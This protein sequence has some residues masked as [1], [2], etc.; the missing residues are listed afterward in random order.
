MDKESDGVTSALEKQDIPHPW[1]CLRHPLSVV[2]KIL[3]LL[4]KDVFQI[5]MYNLWSIQL[6]LFLKQKPEVV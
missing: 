3:F 4:L 6:W 2:L 5:L 1:P